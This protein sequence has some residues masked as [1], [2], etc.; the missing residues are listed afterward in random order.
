MFT[1]AVNSNVL[2]LY[3]KQFS[4]NKEEMRWMWLLADV[5]ERSN[6]KVLLSGS[7]SAK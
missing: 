6:D 5:T 1:V 3:L 7:D 4:S 2:F